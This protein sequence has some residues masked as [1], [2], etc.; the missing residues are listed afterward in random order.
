MIILIA[1]IAVVKREQYPAYPWVATVL[2]ILSA[3]HPDVFCAAGSMSG[4]FNPDMM[5]WKFPPEMANN[6]KNAFGAILGPIESVDYSIYSIISMAD[7]IKK[8]GTKVIFDCGVDD[9]LIE[10]NRE[11]HRRLVF[12]QTPHDYSERPGGH[13]WEYWQ[14]SLPHHVLFFYEVLKTNNTTVN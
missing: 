10:P 4:A 5:G 14:N 7:V 3:R 11:L 13:S 2:Y 8:N 1:P 6:I 9:F 12:N